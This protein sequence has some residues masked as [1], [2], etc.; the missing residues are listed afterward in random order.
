MGDGNCLRMAA[1]AELAEDVLDVGPGLRG[2]MKSCAAICRYLRPSARSWRIS[3]SRLVSR[4]AATE[5]ASGRTRRST[6]RR[7]RTS[8]TP[9]RYA[10]AQRRRTTAE[11]AA[12]FSSSAFV[13]LAADR[14]A[15]AMVSLPATWY[16][17]PPGPCVRNARRGRG[18]SVPHPGRTARG[19]RA[20]H[21]GPR[22]GTRWRRRTAAT[23]SRPSGRR[24]DRQAPERSART[25]RA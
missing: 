5:G 10:D 25:C 12:A 1:N 19:L 3:S 14:I 17:V 4:S 7:T 23:R 11:Y 16:R 21:A 2:L 20:G 8:S 9:A 13:T 6:S 15:G 18:A 24:R 22:C